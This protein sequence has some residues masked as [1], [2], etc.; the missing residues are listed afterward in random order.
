MMEILQDK[1]F[2]TTPLAQPSPV[3]PESVK[4]DKKDADQ[5]FVRREEMKTRL[6]VLD[7]LIRKQRSRIA[8]ARSEGLDVTLLE[9]QLKVLSD[10]HEEYFSSL[11][12]LLADFVDGDHLNGGNA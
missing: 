4:F 11:K 6:S 3:T 1:A 9:E 8:S 7:E 5:H 10:S 2:E 12:R